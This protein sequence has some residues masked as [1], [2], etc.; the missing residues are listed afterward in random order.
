MERAMGTPTEAAELQEKEEERDE[1]KKSGEG[2]KRE[3][4]GKRDGEEKEIGRKERKRERGEEETIPN[5]KPSVH[6]KPIFYCHTPTLV[7]V[8]DGL[9]LP[10]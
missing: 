5:H 3:R 2:E 6:R 9:T 4:G 7:A 1:K 8:M 10:G